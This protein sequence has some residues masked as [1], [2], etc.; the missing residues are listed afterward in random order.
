MEGSGG[1]VGSGGAGID[2]PVDMIAVDAPKETAAEVPSGPFALTSSAFTNGMNVPLMHKCAQAGNPPMG[3][4][5]SPPFGWTSGPAGTMSYAITLNH[6]ASGSKHWAIWDIPADVFAIPS[7]IDHVAMP[8][9]PAGS[10]QTRQTGAGLDGFTGYG[11]LGPCPQNPGLQMYVF[12][13]YAIKTAT[14]PNITITSTVDAVFAAIQS[15][16]VAG[17]RVTLIGT[18]QRQ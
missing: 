18:Q 13:L 4:N 7:N 12:T 6:Q 9:T 2:A 1:T 14:I 8:P 10:K 17:G 16:M 15:N 5:I 3:M 11:Y